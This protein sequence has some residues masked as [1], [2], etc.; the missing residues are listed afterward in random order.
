[1]DF[2]PAILAA[3]GDTESLLARAQDALAW[4]RS[5]QVRVVYVRVAFTPHATPNPNQTQ[6]V[7]VGTRR[8]ADEGSRGTSRTVLA[9]WPAQGQ[10]GAS[11]QARQ[12]GGCASTALR[13]IRG[14]H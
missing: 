7:H 6:T 4:A 1:M 10:F 14:A 11:N 8:L 13:L 5:E 2:Q 12:G 9:D 3:I